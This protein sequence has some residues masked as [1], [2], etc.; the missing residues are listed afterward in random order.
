MPIHWVILFTA[1]AIALQAWMYQKLSLRK[2][3]YERSFSKHKVF[4]GERL[5]MVESIQ[6]DKLLP[7]PWVRLESM[8]PTALHFKSQS[9]LD[10]QAGELSQN[11]KSLFALKA[12]SRIVRTHEITCMKRGVYLVNTATMTAGDLFGVAET[13]RR[14]QLDLELIVYPQLMPIDSIPFSNK[15]WIGD[16][17]V[18]RWILDDPFWKTGVRPYAAGD[19]LRSVHWKAT[20]RTNQLQVHQNGFTADRRLQLLVNVETSEG[21]W[22]KVTHPEAVERA[23]SYAAS[24]ANVTVT[25]GVPTGFSCNA[26]I[27]DQLKGAPVHLSPAAGQHQLDKMYEMMAHLEMELSLSFHTLLEMQLEQ[28]SETDLLIITPLPLGRS[29]TLIHDYRKRG[30]SIEILYVPIEPHKSQKSGPASD[31]EVPHASISS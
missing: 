19:S 13:Y 1:L 23:L 5:E 27:R 26:W 28:S 31:E 10:I 17:T 20:A 21:M 24:I 30:V 2:L 6:N 12:Y 15:S 8:L 14:I 18:K 25:Q 9:N 16:I 7:L 4:A 22:N 11:H 29:Q 3:S